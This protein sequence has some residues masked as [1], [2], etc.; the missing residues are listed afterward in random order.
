MS[1]FDKMQVLD[2]RY[3]YIVVALAI[4]IPLIIPFNS[5]T[6]V[7]VPT[8]NVYKKID[9]FAG[10]KDRAI[11]MCF[12]HDASTMAELFPMEVAI[13]RHCF[14]RK[15]QVF[16]I[17]F[18]PAAKP[19]MDYALQTAKEEYNVQSG[20]DYCNFGY[21]PWGLFLPILLGM[22][23]DIAEAVD[24]DDEGRKISNLEIMKEIKNYNE[25]NLV[26]DFAAS[27]AVYSWITY[28]RA[29]FG[30]NVA[31][32]ITAVMAA[33]NYPYLQT[34]QLIGMLSGL[35]G[36]AEYEKLVDIF[37]THKEPD[38]EGI[39]QPAPREFSKEVLKVSWI[40]LSDIK[41]RNYKTARIG[42]NAQ[43]VA[44]IMI[45]VFIIL[46]NIGYFSSKKKKKA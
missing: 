12:S 45:I 17:C 19:L 44:H 18:M 4:I 21:K 22:G 6:Y 27:A 10:R 32:G 28:A 38:A 3:I 8:E 7:T 30:A 39:L 41:N 40:K 37:A 35:K 5:K 15:I 14:E 42:M 36:A 16:T 26:V 33:D 34:G 23:D 29:R 25:M 46:G 2:R 11:L 43:T 31:A 13:L 24:I 20:I 9:S 1:F